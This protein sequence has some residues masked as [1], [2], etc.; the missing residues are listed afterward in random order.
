MIVYEL[1]VRGREGLTERH[2]LV[3][4][5]FVVGSSEKADLRLAGVEILPVH[6]RL[7]RSGEEWLLVNMAAPNL[8]QLNTLNMETYRPARWQLEDRIKL[9]R[10]ELWIEAVETPDVPAPS[11]PSQPSQPSQPDT[12]LDTIPEI[13]EELPAAEP[14]PTPP[15]PPIPRPIEPPPIQSR[16]PE[17]SEGPLNAPTLRPSRTE[18]AEEIPRVPVPPPHDLMHP[19]VPTAIS[20]VPE[21][22][23]EP[24]PPPPGLPRL[25]LLDDKETLG[26]TP[27]PMETIRPP[28]LVIEW[29]DKPVFEPSPPEP[30][31]PEPPAEPVSQGDQL[32]SPELI[33]WGFLPAAEKLPAFPAAE[34]HAEA[35][36][37]TP[38]ERPPDAPAP[39]FPPVEPL[40]QAP[41]PL[42][43]L[44]EPEA[45]PAPPTAPEVDDFWQRPAPPGPDAPQ[46]APMHEVYTAFFDGAQP[47]QPGAAV[48]P[49]GVGEDTLRKDWRYAGHISAQ[50]ALNEVRLS[51][52]QR[53]RLSISL[54]SQYPQPVQVEVFITGLPAGWFGLGEEALRLQPGEVHPVDAIIQPPPNVGEGVIDAVVRIN[55]S[56]APGVGLALPF[57]VTLRREPNLS[58]WLTPA[59]ITDPGPAHLHI[60]NHTQEAARVFIGG[61]GWGEGLR[62]LPTYPDLILPPGETLI[63]PVRVETEE[64][65]NWFGKTRDF[66]V[67]ASQ[68]SR[69]P[70][71]FP[72]Q[73]RIRP[74]Y[75][76]LWWLVGLILILA[77]CGGLIWGGVSLINRFGLFWAAPTATP[78]PPAPTEIPFIPP[79]PIP[80]TETP[81]PTPTVAPVDPRPATCRVPIPPG[82]QPY[83]V[84]AGDN[85]FRLALNRGIT[86]Q[87]IQRVNCLEGLIAGETILL[88]G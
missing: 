38:T 58:G 32:T 79:T 48:A 78:I 39:Y 27:P 42:D 57:K 81:L 16:P 70:L 8:T 75:G 20:E 17:P 52:G 21:E 41:A 67:S 69:A 13:L 64:R 74:R 59:R 4:S 40:P 12:S 22:E 25:P 85:L 35:D 80:P 28:P 19:D 2:P 15:P 88:P 29:P 63:V 45:S 46:T 18:R 71:D 31:A 77:V 60:R 24:P 47:T 84:Q 5:L 10:Y 49:G 72:G 44:T 3:G 53:V 1:V 30:P 76:C 50:L 7:V 62:V 83:V 23:E 55:D 86:I 68:G 43:H 26:P 73:V 66:W 54:R 34:A 37:A 6:L 82:W 33:D 51:P 36:E 14:P 56:A 9:G 87:D 61:G 11:A 65:P